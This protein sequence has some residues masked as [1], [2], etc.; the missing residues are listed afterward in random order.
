MPLGGPK[1]PKGDLQHNCHTNPITWWVSLSLESVL[2]YET[3]HNDP[4]SHILTCLHKL[5]STHTVIHSQSV[6]HSHIVIY[7]EAKSR[8]KGLFGWSNLAFWT[9]FTKSVIHFGKKKL[10]KVLNGLWL[11]SGSWLWPPYP[12]LI[13]QLPSRPKINL[14]T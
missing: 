2:I 8:S 3:N 5:W 14:V 4:R 7:F 13:N 10:P 11:E 6:I 12:K 9:S 1:A